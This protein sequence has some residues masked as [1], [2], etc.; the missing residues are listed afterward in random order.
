MSP[1]VQT[2]PAGILMK[3]WLINHGIDESKIIVE[4]HSLDSFENVKFGLKELER[5]GIK[6]PKITVVSQWQHALRFKIC[7][8]L[9][10]N[11]K[12]KL[13]PMRYQISLKEFI[14]EF[15]GIIYCL[16]DPT[17]HKS[18]AKKIR[19]KRRK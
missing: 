19:E 3:E 8:Y 15:L 7:F 10:Y 18:I 12:V 5:C 17:G 16:Y 4:K 2:V 13:Y 9:G 6:N 1:Q 11:F 14:Q